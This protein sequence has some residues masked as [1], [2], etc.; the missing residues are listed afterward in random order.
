MARYLR[1]E[2]RQTVAIGRF[3]RSYADASRDTVNMPRLPDPAIAILIACSMAALFASASWHKFR[4][5]RE[6]VAALGAYRLLPASSVSSAAVLLAGLEAATALGLLVSFTRAIAAATGCSLLLLYAGAVAVNLIRGRVNLDCG[7]M[8]PTQR[9]P[10]RAWMVGRN[11]ALTVYLGLSTL[12]PT[13][14]VL[15]AT[16]FITVGAGTLVVV[17][18]YAI[19]EEWYRIGAA[20]PSLRSHYP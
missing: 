6:F 17:L 11:V 14:R 9:Q 16:D 8:G 18:L 2:N 3:G 1:C 7:C 19:L 5:Y 4:H 13:D 20:R 10:I 12:T 15:S